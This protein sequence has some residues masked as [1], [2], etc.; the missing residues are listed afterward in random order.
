MRSLKTKIKNSL[1][2]ILF[3]I[4]TMVFYYSFYSIDFSKSDNILF[5]NGTII[6][7]DK[8]HQY[9]EAVYVEN[10]IIKSIG[11]F[12]HIKKNTL[13]STIIVDLNGRTLMPGFIDSHT[14]PVISSFLYDMIDLSGFTHYS[15]EKVWEHLTNEVSNY[16]PNDWILCKG[17]DQ[18]LVP[19]LTPPSISYLDSIAPN[20]PLLIAS[21]SLHSYWANSLAF[22]ASGIKP[23]T[24]DP[25][26]SS[27][28]ERDSLGKFTGYIAEQTA[29]QPFKNTILKSIGIN[30]LK[31]N[32]RMVMKEYLKNGYTSITSMGITTADKKVI[33]LYKHISSKRSNM[34]N[35]ILSIVGILPNREH[36]ARNFVFVRHDAP[37]LLPESVANGDDFF[38]IMG[39]K[40][41]YDGSPYTGSMYLE[42]PYIDNNFTNNIL[43]IPQEHTG[44]A[45][46]T[47]DQIQKN[48]KKYQSGNWQVAIHTQG[49]IA[50]R[51]VLNAFE[52]TQ[53][54]INYRHRLEHCLL[55]NSTS[56]ERMA[57]INVYPSFHIN[58]LYYYGNVLNNKLIGTQRA[59]RMLPIKSAVDNSLKFTIHADQPMFPSEPFSLLSTAV[60]RKTKEGQVIGGQHA[61]TIYQ[62]LKALTIDAAW[63][64]KMDEKIGSIKE[65]KYG[66]LIILN[67]NPLKV[68][69]TE[70]R[71]IKVLDI[72]VHGNQIN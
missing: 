6:T 36:T 10:G 30:K 34:L 46:L 35:N 72:Y 23:S 14:H 51:E 59:N 22:Q 26:K 70:L 3:S 33:Q 47:K 28:Y 37:H 62:A 1:P 57:N 2:V 60:N 65:G 13:S 27:Y 45:L 67:R 18:V 43:H 9:P 25:S 41:W 39:I 50:I 71:N 31:N 5:H 38:R 53:S 8:Q 21:Q 64:I 17:F 58:H 15:K 29:F 42:E 20:N 12:D 66:D 24:P 49:D 52:S 19:G 61:I 56:I 11:S 7:M 16:N 68:Q 32:S 44:K 4:C 54:K 63:Q 40:F 55:I 69:K 48:I